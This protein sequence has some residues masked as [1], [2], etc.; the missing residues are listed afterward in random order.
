[1][2]EAWV[3]ILEI[4]QRLFYLVQEEL[5]RTL[6]PGRTQVNMIRT[7]KRIFRKPD[8]LYKIIEK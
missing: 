6:K 7:K 2:A 8:E 3:F 4:Q 5:V 1:M